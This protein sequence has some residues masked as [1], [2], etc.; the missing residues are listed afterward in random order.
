MNPRYQPGSH[1]WLRPRHDTIP[2]LECGFGSW[3]LAVGRLPL[4]AGE[5]GR[6]YDRVARR[7]NRALGRLGYP[8]AYEGLLRALLRANPLPP[9]RPRVLDCGVGTGALSLALARAVA[10][11]FALE[12]IDI[13][14]R[15]LARA[16]D[17][18]RLGG[19]DA[20]LRLADLRALPYPD[21]AFDLVMAAH[22]VEHVADP[23]QALAE[24]TRVLAPGGRLV[25]CLTR[26]SFA[27]MLVQLRWRTHRVSATRAQR[28]LR[29]C[30]LQHVATVAI[31]EH[32][33]FSRL[34]IACVGTKP[35]AAARADA[36]MPAGA[37]E[38]S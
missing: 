17:A 18:F 2:V 6:R 34:S 15:M 36:A 1:L 26:R 5:L 38:V 14:P 28:W 24:M 29:Q 16:R 11:D 12:A 23:P 9:R 30:G 3:R 33:R 27:G 13:S 10:A 21:R 35:P 25:V 8:R 7:W 19:L 31:E 4:S 37:E 32:R 22:V 20:R